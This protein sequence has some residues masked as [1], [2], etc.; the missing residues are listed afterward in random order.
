MRHL[1]ENVFLYEKNS[2]ECCEGSSKINV[3]RKKLKKYTVK[4][5]WKVQLD[6]KLELRKESLEIF[7]KITYVLVGKINDK[8]S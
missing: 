5:K 3:T 1:G 6:W 7:T 8:S 2:H 4:K